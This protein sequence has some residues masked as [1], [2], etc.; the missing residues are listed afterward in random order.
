[1]SEQT[2]RLTTALS[3]YGLGSD[4]AMIYLLLLRNGVMS[5]LVISREIHIARTKVYRIL[6]RLLAKNII[7][8]RLD[9][10]GK[11][12][13]ANSYKE[14]EMLVTEKEADV[15]RLRQELPGMFNELAMV[16]GKSGS[17]SK[18][19][20]YS[21]EDGLKQITWN[22]TRTR[23]P[24]RIFERSSMN[25]FMT[26]GFAEKI[27]EEFVEN[28]VHVRQLTNSI[29]LEPY[30]KNAEH[31]RRMES[32]YLN[33]KEMEIIFEMLIYDDVVAI[34]N[35]T[36]EDKFGVEIY[37]DKLART[38]KQLFDFIWNKS[39]KMKII[40]DQGEAVLAS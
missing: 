8:I 33:P 14:L 10:Q 4:E 35:Y 29:H 19:L 27:R 5:A 31:V 11:K 37:N 39:R 15:Q 30:T 22:S 38:Q 12:F 40:N 21:E 6:D 2:D 16:V 26:F 23:D 13:E 1:M 17:R 20:Y 36:D 32:R 24:L 9:D 28:D 18:V 7:N 25:A 3:A 34:Y